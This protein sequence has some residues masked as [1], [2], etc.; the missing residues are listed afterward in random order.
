MTSAKKAIKAVAK[1]GY[2]ALPW[3]VLIALGVVIV[4]PEL[5]RPSVVDDGMTA[6]HIGR[7]T[8]RGRIGSGLSSA[9]IL[10][11]KIEAVCAN[12]SAKRLLLVIDSAGGSPAQAERVGE[13]I[14]RCSDRRAADLS[15][16]AVIGDIGASAA[17]MIAAHANSIIAGRYST[18]G[19]IG[20]VSRQLDLSEAAAELGI[21]E[22]I[23][24]SGPLKGGP[25]LWRQG[26]EAEKKVTQAIVDD[27]ADVFLDDVIRL[28]GLTETSRA[29]LATGRMWTS[30]DARALGLT[31]QIAT[32]E[33]LK[34]TKYHVPI[35][36]YPAPAERAGGETYDASLGGSVEDAVARQILNVARGR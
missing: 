3:V 5:L 35:I 30:E 2:T 31:D 24:R 23:V 18:V 22:Q 25:S 12:P 33:E 20:M 9:D 34:A 21:T 26:S 32:L 6:P 19:S 1:Y 7:V 36:E 28:R 15:V 29:Q 11:A 27:L 4:R 17:Y 10:T 14:D 16:D 8:I 13:A